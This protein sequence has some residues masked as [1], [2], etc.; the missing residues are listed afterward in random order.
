VEFAA[1]RERLGPAADFIPASRGAS[2]REVPGWYAEAGEYRI[3]VARSVA[4]VVHTCTIELPETLGP[5]A[6]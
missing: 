6:P 3:H 4:D 5:L 1:Q 2:H